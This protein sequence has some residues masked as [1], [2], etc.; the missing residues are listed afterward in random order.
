MEELVKR[1][2]KGLFKL[3]IITFVT[4][5]LGWYGLKYYFT[6]FDN[7]SSQ[8]R[9]AVF[10]QIRA[11]HSRFLTYKD[12]PEMYLDAVVATEDRSF[13][14]NKGID[15]RGTMRS[16]F[17]DISSGQPLQGGSTITQQ[18]IH[19]T[20]LRSTPK[21]LLWKFL[22]SIYAIGVYDTMSKQETIAFY[23]NVIYF[24]HGGYGLYEAA[25]NYF[26]KAPSELNEG[27][28][29]MLAGLPN[30]PSDYDPY[31][32]MTLARERQHQVVQN[33]VDVGVINE[34]Q[35]N[36][37]LNQPIDLRS[38]ASFNNVKLVLL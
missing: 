8:V 37:I 38:P 7:I 26:G 6:H 21:S 24:G 13:F 25:E 19:N 34:L 27:E 31:R 29:T 23:S 17:V 4:F 30:A 3:L 2:I 1:F 18:L 12:I 14:S 10:M 33:M 22:E 9:S 16:V 36:K 20:L 32:N 28:L 11:K 35:A 5:C 15:I